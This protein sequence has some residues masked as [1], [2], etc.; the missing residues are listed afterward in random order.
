MPAPYT[1]TLNA[2]VAARLAMSPRLASTWS[3]VCDEVKLPTA[4][5]IVSITVPLRGDEPHPTSD[6]IDVSDTQ[7]DL[8]RLVYPVRKEP[9]YIASPMLTPCMVTLVEPVAPVLDLDSALIALSSVEKAALMLARLT[10]AVTCAI[11]L[12]IPPSAARQS[13]AVSECQLVASQAVCWPTG[14]RPLVVTLDM[15]R[16]AP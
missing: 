12:R 2:P 16:L 1:V 8:Q 11:L 5:Q 10:S 9:V 14:S 15:P 6:R 4:L 7:V 13:K 3:T